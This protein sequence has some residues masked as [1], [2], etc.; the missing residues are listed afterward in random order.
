MLLLERKQHAQTARHS[1]PLIVSTHRSVNSCGMP[2]PGRSPGLTNVVLQSGHTSHGEGIDPQASVFPH[3]H[4]KYGCCIVTSCGYC[5]ISKIIFTFSVS[6]R[7]V[8]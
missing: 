7:H 1:R 2:W 4:R 5:V 6:T 3:R 8:R